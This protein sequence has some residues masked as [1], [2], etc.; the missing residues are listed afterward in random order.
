MKKR[1]ISLI[2]ALVMVIG[3]LP[4]NVLAAEPAEQVQTPQAVTIETSLDG[5]LTDGVFTTAEEPLDVKIRAAADGETVEHTAKL[6]GEVLEGTPEEDG[7]TTYV[8]SFAQSGSYTLDISA[9]DEEQ[10]RTIVYQ[11]QDT[12]DGEQDVQEPQEDPADKSSDEPMDEV[13]SEDTEE[14][15]T[16]EEAADALFEERSG[17]AA[18]QEIDTSDDAGLGTVRVIIENTTTSGRYGDFWMAGASEWTGTRVDTSV[19]LKSDSNAISVIADAVKSLGEGHTIYGSVGSKTEPTDYIAA[20][21]GLQEFSSGTSYG[22]WYISLNDWFINESGSSYKVS[23]GNLQDGDEVRAMY[24][25]SGA[26]LGGTTEN[27]NKTLSALTV[28]GATLNPSFSSATNAYEL[29]IGEKESASI[30]LTP[31][32]S[33]KNFL[34]CVFSREVSQEEAAD[35][36]E[37]DASSWFCGK[38]LVHRGESVTVKPG[39]KL[40]V[41]VG[42]AGWP[43]QNSWSLSGSVDTGNPVIY[44]L[45]VVKTGTDHSADFN[46]FFTALEGVA[47]VE[48]DATYPLKVDADE[49]ALVSTNQGKAQV[50]SGVK[51]TFQK[52]AKLSFQY[53]TDCVGCWSY[54]KVAQ[55]GTHVN[56]ESYSV[57]GNYQFSGAM[58]EYRTYE[59]EASTGDV[60]E[61]GFFKNFADD[62]DEEYED[63]AWLKNFTVTLPNAVTFHANDGT[64]VT[65]KQDIFGTANLT[66][67]TFTREGYR[68]DGWAATAGGK[69]Q[70]ADG[71]EITLTQNVDLYAVWT[72]VWNVTFPHMQAGAAITVKQNGEA[73]PVSATA[74]TW[75]VPN[76]SYT[77][78]AELFG[79]V[80]KTD[81]AF[82]VKDAD[83]AVNESL[84][85]A[86]RTNVTFAVGG[87]TEGT[88][89]T[90]TVLNS[91]NTRMEPTQDGGKTYALPAGKYT[92]TVA[93]QGYKKLKNQ[94]LTVEVG[95]TERTVSVTLEVSAAWDGKAVTTPAQMNGVYQ[96]GSGAE[97]AGFAKL[98]N[99]GETGAK[100][101][102]TADIVLNDDGEFVHQW[103]P[104]A[105]TSSAPFTGSLIGNGRIISGLY[106][107]SKEKAVGLFGYVGNGGEISNVTIEGASVKST[108]SSGAYAALAVASNAGSISNVKLENSMV[109]G[110]FIVGGVVGLNDGTVTGCANESATVEQNTAKD[111]GVGGIVGQNNAAVSLSYNKA[112]IVRGHDKTSYSYL[113][114]IVG[115]NSGGSAVVE[116]SYNQGEVDIAYY[117]GGI[118]GKANGKITN[119]YNTGSIP[120]KKS[121]IVG[122]N[123]SAKITNCYFL[124]TCGAKDNKG[125]SK[126]AE[127]FKTLAASLGGAYENTDTYPILKWQ[128]P[129]ATY[130]ITLTVKPARANVTL[131][132][133]GGALRSEKTEDTEKD[134]AT[135]TYT[136]LNKGNYTWSVS[137]GEGEDDYQAQS[138]TISLG[139]ADETRRV[140]LAAKEYT[141]T[142]QLTP[143]EAE[144]TLTQGEGE[145]AVTVMPKTPKD[146]NGK[147]VYS[148]TKGS[149]NYKA[150]AF[151]YDDASATLEVLKATGL[152]AQNIALTAK[153]GS[154][155]TFTNVPEG[156]T[157][158]VTHAEGGVQ[159]Q[160]SNENGTVVYTLVPETYSYR[161]KR[162]GFKAMSGTVTMSGSPESIAVTLSPLG[163][164]DGTVGTAF[165]GSGT[166]DDPY[167]IESGEELA[168][169][170]KLVA[171]G[172]DTSGIYYKLTEDIDLNNIAFT[173]IGTTTSLQFKGSFNGAG[174]TISNLKVENNVSLTGLFGRVNAATISDLTIDHATISSTSGTN[175]GVLAGAVYSS[176]N[177]TN[178]VVKHSTVTGK[179]NFTGGLVGY[180]GADI[181]RCAVIDTTVNGT[182]YVGGMFGQIGKKVTECYVLRGT[183]TA[184]GNYAGG[185]LGG[186]SAQVENC[187]VRS[188]TVTA[189]T[190]YAG[191]IIGNGS[192]KVKNTYA[193]ADVSSESG[194][195]GSLGGSSTVTVSNAFY[196]KD[197]TITGSGTSYLTGTGKTTAELKSDAIATSL[198]AA[199]ARYAED[200]GY[201]NA[202]FPYLVN[203]PRMEKIN[204]EQL[205]RPVIA[206]SGK[207]VGWREIANAQG[208][209]VVLT[210]NGK[211][212]DER[213]VTQTSVDYT[214]E[215]DLAGS[216]TYT[217]QVTAL[218]DGEYYTDSSA[219][220]Q[221]EITVNSAS[222][223]I[224]VVR[225]D[226]EAFAENNQPAI[227]L[228]MADGT[229]TIAFTNGET[230]PLPL[231]QYT[232][233]VKA[234]TFGTLNGSFELTA[235]G[236][237]LN[238]T[239]AYSAVWDGETTLEPSQDEDG[240]YLISNSYEL[241]WFRDQV[242][243]QLTNGYTSCMLNAKLTENID[244]G[245]H[246]WTAIAKVTDTSE[247]KGYAGTFNGDGHT[248]SNLKPVGSEVTSYGK[249]KI[250][251]AGLFG[252]VY[253]G[254]TVQNVTVSGTLNAVQY[255]GGV[256]AILAGGT[257]ENCVSSMHVTS[258]LSTNVFAGGIVGNINSKGTAPRVIGCRNDGIIEGGKNSYVG[259]I[260]GQVFNS[261]ALISN[262][263]NT[264]A[265]SGKERIGGIVGSSSAAITA[266]W[267]TG[268]VT[269]TSDEIGGIAGFSSGDTRNCYNS[270]DVAGVG[271]TNGVG[272]I[273]GRLQSENG[274]KVTGC[275]VSGSVTASGEYFGAIVGSKGGTSS[276]ITRSY[277]LNTSSTKAIGSNAAE[278]DETTPVTA[279]ELGA[280][281]LIGLLGGAFASGSDGKLVLNWQDAQ[282]K[283]VVSFV[284]PDGATVTVTGQSAAANEPGV[285]V[286]TDGTYTYT[287]SKTGCNAKTD[288][289]T[290]SGESQSIE[291]SLE[292]ETFQVT[293]NVQ[294][295]GAKIV[296]RSEAGEEVAPTQESASIYSLPN[297]KYT[298]TVS[299]LGCMSRSGEFTVNGAAVVIPAITLT[300]ATLYTVTLSFQ[301]EDKQSV[302]PTSVTVKFDGETVDPAEGTFT[303][304][305]PNGKYTCLVDDSRYYKVEE[306]FTVEDAN[307]TITVSLETNRSWDGK[308]TTEVTPNA[309][310]VY[311]IKTAAELAWFAAQ[312]NAGNTG[313][314]AK[315]MANIYVNYNGSTNVWTPIGGFK[316][317]YAGTF[318]GNGKSIYG[319]TAA[320]FS[321]NAAKS[322]VKNLTV[323]GE[324]V[325]AEANT[326]TMGGICNSAYGSFENC[327]SHMTVTATWSVVGGIVGRLYPGG[328]ITNC[329]NYG[330]VSTSHT[331]S[332]VGISG[333]YNYSYVGGIV[334]QSYGAVTGCFNAGSV[335]SPNTNY[336]GV[337]GIAGVLQNTNTTVME[338]YNTGAVTGYMRTGGIIGAIASE[339][340]S[341]T[342]T[343]KNCYDTGK[344]TLTS[345]AYNPFGGAIAGSIADS[346]GVLVGSVENCYYLTGSRLY[347]GQDCG[348]GYAGTEGSDTTVSKLESEM[349]LD[350]F[351]LAL[352]PTDKHFNVDSENNNGGF[353]VLTW[354]GGRLP[355]ASEDEKDVAAD[356]AELTVE[357]TTVTSAMQLTLASSGRNGSTITWSS[358]NTGVIANDGTVTLPLEN[359]VKVTLTATIT[360]NNVTDTKQFQ[361]LVKTRASADAA[362][363]RAILEKLPTS[364]RV[365]YQQTPVNVTSALKAKLAD[366]IAKSGVSGLK[367][368]DITVTLKSAGT[369]SYGSDTNPIAQDGAV[370]FYYQDP[371]T[372]NINGDL[373]VREVVFQL[374]TDSGVK[375]ETAS[376]MV[377]IPW[378]QARVKAAM[379]EAAKALTF[380]TIKNKNTDAESVSTDLTL[381][382]QLP[383]YGWSLIGWSSDS[384][385]IQVTG[386]SG[387][388]AFTG[389]V[390]AAE[391][392][393]NVKLTATFTFNRNNTGEDG[394]ITVTKEIPVKVPGKSN[395]YM[396]EINS[397][398]EKFTLE[399]LTYMNGEHKGE[400]IDPNAVTDN[401]QLPK[402]ALNNIDAGRNGYAL[403][404]DARNADETIATCPVSVNSY[405]AYVSRPLA[406]EPVEVILKLTITKKEN[407]VLNETYKNSKELRIKISPI[408]P[409]DIDAEIALLD[410]VKANLF[411]GINDDRN[412]AKEAVTQNLH[413]F[414]EG[415]LDADGKLVWIYDEKNDKGVGIVPTDLPGYDS[416]SGANWRLF[417]S[418]NEA[419]IT[420]ENLLVTPDAKDDKTITI[421]ANL[422]SARFGGYYEAYKDNA[423]YSSVLTKLQRLAGELVAVD[424]TVISTANQT[425]A[426][427]TVAKIDA[428]GNVTK[429]SGTKITGARDAYDALTDGAKRLVSNL[430]TL[431]DAEAAFKNLSG[432]DSE[433]D[434]KAAD[435]VIAKIDEIGAIGKDSGAKITEAE[436]AY[437]ELN[438]A[439]KGLVGDA[440]YKKLTDAKAAQ[441]VYD[442][443][444]ALFPVSADSKN[445]IAQA[446]AAYKNLNTEAKALLPNAESRLE[447]AWKE[448]QAAAAAADQEQKDKAAAEKVDQ[449]IDAIGEVTLEKENQITKARSEYEKLNTAATGH[450]KK[451][452]VLEAAEAKLNELK[453][454]Q[455]YV[456]QLN[457]VLTYIK[458]AVDAPAAAA[459]TKAEW[460][461]LSAARAG[462][463]TTAYK[464]WYAAYA[465]NLAKMLKQNGGTFSTTNEYARIVLAL[466]ALGQDAKS[467]AANGTTYDLVTPL[468]EKS[469][470][471]YKATVPGTTSTAFAIIA[472]D[473]HPYSVTDSNAVSAMVADLLAKQHASGAWAINAKYPD[474]DVDTT[475]MILMALAPHKSE[476]GVQAAI[477]KAVS[478]LAEVQGTSGYGNTNTDAQVVT[479]LSALGI[480]CTKGEFVKGS[481]NP[482]TGLLSHQMSSGGFKYAESSVSENQLATEQ[483]AYAL[484]AYD[485]FKC[486]QN[487]LY[488]M[489]DAQDLLPKDTSAE[490]VIDLID[491][492]GTVTDCSRSTYLK[493]Q[494]IA[495]AYDRLTDAQKKDVSN[496][497]TFLR[498]KAKFQTLL[499]EYRAAC[500][501]ELENYY[502][503]L[504][505]S[506]YTTTQWNKITEAYRNGRASISSAQYAEQADAA[507][508]QAKEDIAAYAT[509]D[510]IEVTFRLIGD[511]PESYTNDHLGYVN[512][513]ETEA[514]TLKTGST[515]YDLFSNALKDA[516]LSSTGTKDYIS[517]IT[518][519][520]I[521]GGYTLSEFSN[522][523][524]SG[525]MFTVNGSHGNYAASEHVLK[526]GD[527]V[528][529]HYVDNYATEEKAFTW[530]EAED[531]T[532]SEYV[533]RHISDVATA[534]KNGSVEPRLTTSDLGGTVKFTFKP[535]AGYH[536]KD[537]KV[538][539]KSI[540]AV[541]SYTYKGLKIYSRITVEFTNGSMPFTDVNSRDWFYDD[542]E[543]V[544]NAGLFAGTTATTFS[545]K[546][547]MTRAMLVTVLYR[548]EG[549]PGVTGTSAFDDV[550][551]GAY[552]E[553]AVIWAAKHEIVNGVS[554]TQFSPNTNVTREQMAAI[555][556]RYAQYKSYR[557][558]ATTSLKGFY[559]ANTVSGY[560]VTP[561]QW[562]VAEK[563][564]N[565]SNGSLLPRGNATRAQVAAILHRFV[566]NVVK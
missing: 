401:I 195:Y 502:N 406:E 564:V 86:A 357:P 338:C 446:E 137:C 40:S 47:T 535:D 289:F 335:A 439:A 210:K 30:T 55:N 496:Y 310:G 484:V 385:V 387:V 562:A 457:N 24:Y 389:V 555:L 193:V 421:T 169:L 120:S 258:E 299:K 358:S 438:D 450:V 178:C 172:V 538:D 95:Q 350:A 2:L 116:N 119:C 159:N 240:T 476:A 26:D 348:I 519:P 64:D 549:E 54:L 215:I 162:K 563:L 364:Y 8:L 270:G 251:G 155:L 328:S 355:E 247:S 375:A 63:C 167:Q 100:G 179:S 493:I 485:R 512:W 379:L 394:D 482:L 275:L 428:I 501:K 132:N 380:D 103:T 305:L 21:D 543:Y 79:Y 18:E 475:A 490:E 514:Y 510:T 204:P 318:D 536:V 212:V 27:N 72:K 377:A 216:G 433:A 33:N 273:V 206:W 5:E 109:S 500:L 329:A 259:G 130:T 107:D 301:D 437:N 455:G 441:T 454:D 326:G 74:N 321:Y 508:R 429:D 356:K 105:K 39:D 504:N 435:D 415:Y 271:K 365:A 468:T 293:F 111:Q 470:S 67:N 157:V 62:D 552:Y 459:D 532:P 131:S 208:Y 294:P 138:S 127:E 134:E 424:V 110:G 488:R 263:T 244:L 515:V 363:L 97:L 125:T 106:I 518:A 349:K 84:E 200:D 257:V 286:L 90:I 73:L 397:A 559:D 194:S 42:A 4:V 369:V 412:V 41:V 492:L 462:C 461:V 174:N 477:E 227:T 525:W 396:T 312:V 304:S 509:G 344:I 238:L 234:K 191:G 154:T 556:Y 352:S 129:N 473:S 168:Y 495:S 76:G 307:R 219:T 173:P 346:D 213:T 460:A 150:T 544:Y 425:A 61:V 12:Q 148:L 384:N 426:A 413:A 35:K 104:I 341:A 133:G 392:D 53:K 88:E 362:A 123:A 409:S 171:D 211:T 135:Y 453:N 448:Y 13:L 418:S 565:G 449:L 236:K 343:V 57:S 308:T 16:L 317:Q 66:K 325:A 249:T 398:L 231:G 96:I 383:N 374:I 268:S 498:Q 161:V 481:G 290:V 17:D 187:F 337:G 414:R 471:T 164:W 526:D 68:F 507:L 336:G 480:D 463:D 248:I 246:D 517:G 166:K 521:L 233:T 3:I 80:S 45:E 203:A 487:P 136:G 25:V 422:K 353:P 489:S 322:L 70:Y 523:P 108:S 513:I 315:L 366:A 522:G 381:P 411:V 277:Y 391:N 237:T 287:V 313:Y 6:D 405:A 205:A 142:F 274:G 432:G 260:T 345:D 186:G 149:Y 56:K 139:V 230:K 180:S 452:R 440:N 102:L 201:I 101:V 404:Y 71:A 226:G 539:G 141:V 548:L 524:A 416:M 44:T 511:F 323:D 327:V 115:N 528:V 239:M 89:V 50:L 333:V 241:A 497:D 390:S 81:V 285:Y 560:A 60:V 34:A 140:E 483:A 295:D 181:S 388:T 146:E 319:L 266:C 22:G 32:A 185:L 124:D 243:G 399:S 121:A 93:A 46:R 151:G 283:P 332:S 252:Y 466:T 534:G 284:V 183:V 494:E 188:V 537:V 265:V 170:S 436:N 242:N 407:N 451:L 225:A 78:S 474:D 542:V 92:Y 147:V 49:N 221:S 38:G 58:S 143:A 557:T 561:M 7:W 360:K 14:A 250:Q 182:A 153:T 382:Q 118:V 533:H 220:A 83:Y 545:P 516:G 420:C 431:I 94:P 400:E 554:N 316:N 359:D 229:T 417:R 342:A 9:A 223:T 402:K 113:G 540:G 65:S 309:D 222:V 224:S 320:L 117:V 189:S 566:E 15:S 550:V 456:N 551:R 403:V 156:A 176:S 423:A 245:S 158:T 126:T 434:K 491:K 218:G 361:I 175:T 52:T 29:V 354:Q 23:V 48:N 499:E 114:G 209:A 443:I 419:V 184:S 199:F 546:A 112:H 370:T 410:Q 303:Y 372:C 469:G 292:A 339:T 371:A 31:T 395:G 267:N 276:V 261:A 331:A 262:C 207:T 300:G 505:R 314:N 145:S 255:S 43:T 464:T 478:Y 334:G 427:A 527:R 160:T 98:V 296:V 547:S 256:V 465:D 373:T 214:T 340:A 282:S 442:Q 28:T 51:I 447:Q 503:K 269:G 324:N 530:L 254:G 288:E 36:T 190:G 444:E 192:A 306:S 531:I 10:S 59:I 228:T 367:A 82:E 177:I 280:K 506:N 472:L 163:K 298:Y 152:A 85:S 87:V 347:N 253:V 408:K 291:V 311:E 198:G 128:N 479:A 393:T 232:Y 235:E 368:D 19:T 272:G 378:D 486:G 351:A 386:G 69:V 520:D 1:V 458:G 144:L 75:I 553:D 330:T 445:A 197:S 196:C 165:G 302:T 541:D 11:A 279:D 529:W 558:S 202:G 297:G 278:T 37:M 217:V 281:R 77:Y 376:C 467:F 91:E 430:Q 264:A 20:I 122:Y 99:D